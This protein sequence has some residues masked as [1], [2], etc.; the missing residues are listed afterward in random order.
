MLN[1]ITSQVVVRTNCIVAG[2][3]ALAQQTVDS[4]VKCFSMNPNEVNDSHF[5]IDIDLPQKK[6]YMFL[7]ILFLFLQSLAFHLPP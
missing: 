2:I 3:R 6:N 1:L 4:M 7:M 5:L